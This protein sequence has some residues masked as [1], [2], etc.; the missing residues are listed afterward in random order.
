MSVADCKIV[1][2]DMDGTLLNGEAKISRETWKACEELQQRGVKLLLSTGRPFVSARIASDY[3]PFDGYVCSNGA[4]LFT[5]DG[6]LVKYAELPREV[7]I[8]LVEISRQKDIYYEVHD[9]NSNRWMVEE[10]KER[11]GEMLFSEPFITEGITLEHTKREYANRQFSYNELAKFMLKDELVSKIASG[12]FVISKMFFWHK[13]TNVLK[14]LREQTTEFVGQ[15]SLT[16]SGPFNMEVIP[17]GLSK[18]VGLQ[19]FMQKWNVPAAEIAAFGDAM[20]D[21]EI[22]SHVGHPVVMENAQDEVKKLA[23]YMAKHHCEDG[24][25]CFIREYMLPNQ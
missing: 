5:E 16:S 8:S 13:D 18:W 1:A 2:F 3:Y 11:I 12:E 25:A 7:I 21:F 4:A 24:V 9:Q 17:L 14:W 19:T 15:V 23:R 10:D 6:T 22:L 20:N